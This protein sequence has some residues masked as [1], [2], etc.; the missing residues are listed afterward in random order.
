METSDSI[1]QF[2]DLAENFN[3]EESDMK[4]FEAYLYRKRDAVFSEFK[5]SLPFQIEDIE[6]IYYFKYLV[7]KE[8]TDL[9]K[10]SY[11]DILDILGWLCVF[12]PAEIIR[13][14]EDGTIKDNYGHFLEIL[15]TY[16][17][18]IDQVKELIEV[19]ICFQFIEYDECNTI[20]INPKIAQLIFWNWGVCLF[21]FEKELTINDDLQILIQDIIIN[22]EDSFREQKFYNREVKKILFNLFKLDRDDMIQCYFFEQ[23]NYNIDKKFNLLTKRNLIKWLK[24]YTRIFTNK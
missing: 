15:T 3:I 13:S 4:M 23:L 8:C 14:D 7:C 10:Y 18:N 2:I 6:N 22:F 16:F 20:T 11:S 21:S 5:P 12:S 24:D 1:K 9:V 17:H 19:L